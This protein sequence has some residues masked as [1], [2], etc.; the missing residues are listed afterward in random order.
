MKTLG[1]MAQWT[2]MLSIALV[3]L[4]SMCIKK[5]YY[6]GPDGSSIT[7]TGGSNESPELSYLPFLTATA[8]RG[9]AISFRKRSLLCLL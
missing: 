7:I 5:V 6:H 9:Q 8:K 1:K 4:F 3:I 2:D